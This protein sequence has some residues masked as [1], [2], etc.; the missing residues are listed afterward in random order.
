MNCCVSSYCADHSQL[1]QPP[2]FSQWGWLLPCIMEWNSLNH[3]MYLC[4]HKLFCI[5]LNINFHAFFTVFEVPSYFYYQCFIMFLELNEVLDTENG[6][7]YSWYFY[8]S[9]F[10]MNMA[11]TQLCSIDGIIKYQLWRHYHYI[12][13]Y[14]TEITK[15]NKTI[16]KH[17]ILII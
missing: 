13:Y 2:S 14:N 5:F 11:T 7:Q 16:P 4:C 8:W 15:D 6:F 10:I 9:Q 3:L 1:S 17:N 12:L